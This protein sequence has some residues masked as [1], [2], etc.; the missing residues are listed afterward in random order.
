MLNIF[1]YAAK[2]IA[3]IREI[4]LHEKIDWASAIQE[5]RQKEAGLDLTHVSEILK[6]IPKSEFDMVAWINKPDVNSIVALTEEGR[7][8]YNVSRRRSEGHSHA[9]DIARKYGLLFD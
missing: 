7:Q 9:K 5:A 3:D 2:D 8:I 1:R 6:S 4:A